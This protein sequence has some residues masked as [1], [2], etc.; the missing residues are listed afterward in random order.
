MEERPF[1]DI[2]YQQFLNEEKLMG[3][4]CKK[5]GALYTPPRPICVKCKGYEMEWVEMKGKGKLSAFTVVTV[6]PPWM[7]KLGYDRKNPYCSGVVTLEEGTRVVARIEDVDAS[8]PESIKVGTPLAVDYIHL[9]EGE[10]R[11][12]LLAFKSS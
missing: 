10:E 1:S 11:E 12:T 7:V 8:N 3:S 9:G 6:G 5:C 2:S 4:K